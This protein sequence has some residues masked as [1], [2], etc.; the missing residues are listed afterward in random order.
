MTSTSDR[1]VGALAQLNHYTPVKPAA[2]APLMIALSRQAGAGGREIASTAAA[3]LGWPVYDHELLQHIAEKQGLKAHLLEDLD[4]RYVGWIEEAAR[5]FWAPRG[6]EVAA[7]LR[8]LR[9][10]LATLSSMGR[11]V[12]VGHGAPHLL[13]RETTLTVRV[14]GPRDS[15]IARV[16]QRKNLSAAEAERWI[17]RTER[18]RLRFLER[19]F[20]ANDA[21]PF[22]YDLVL[23]RGR[24]G[25]AECADLIVQAVRAREPHS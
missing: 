23:N 18:E 12:I 13:P 21:D 25:V 22:A 9:D 19:Y 2:A 7:Y 10:Q 5:S 24:L 8:G 1:V 6:H 3:R 16:Q 20:N 11:C 17:E 15:R 14:I 4:E